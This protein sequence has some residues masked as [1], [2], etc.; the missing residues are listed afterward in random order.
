M[1][2]YAH[3]SVGVIHVRPLLNLKQQS[4]V[5][6]MASISQQAFDLVREYGGSW[7]GEHGDGLV[8][9]YKVNE[10]FGDQIYSA[11]KE[12][13]ATFDP[14]GLMNPGKIVDAPSMTENLRIHPGYETDFPKTYYRFSQEGGLDKAIELCTGVGQC[15]K[16]LQGVMCPS[17]I[18]T[19]DEEH[20]T[21]GR[22]NALRS[23]IAGDLG[24]EG[25]T[26]RRLFEVLDL[27]LECKACKSECPSNVDMAKMKAEF[28]A[29][30][31]DRHGVPL[32]KRIVS[33]TR[34]LAEFSSHVPR[35]SNAFIR[36][37][38]V[39]WFLE[40]LAGIDRRRQL[41]TYAKSTLVKWCASRNGSPIQRDAE[42]RVALFV[43]T[44]VNYYE[45]RIGIAAVEV[46]EAL[47]FDVELAD[48]GCCGRPLISAGLLEKAKLNGNRILRGL[49]EFARDGVPIVVLEP[50]CFST[51]KDDFPDLLDD[52][53]ASRL[54]A[55][56]VYSFEGFLNREEIAPRL[57]GI[58][59]SGPQE[60]LFHGHC[61]QRALT[62]IEDSCEVLSKLENTEVREVE[63]GCCGMAGVF[64]YE[65]KH[66]S[67]SEKI[68]GRNLFPAVEHADCS[69]EVVAGGFSCR[70]Q[71]AHFTGKQ[72]LHPAEILADALNTGW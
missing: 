49:E 21:R 1:A 43:D 7:S 36:N 23:A 3:A 53:D 61:Q 17:F 5:E 34:S 27:C 19:R 20:S 18:A 71:I 48:V 6:I 29:H 10:F 46:L 42:K 11:F 14:S 30:Y 47:G 12:V 50:S 66:Y 22:A 39:R 37:R 33:M 63:P 57:R 58:L 26:S 52:I 59:G 64:G 70:S 9:S 55:Q 68:G 35:L 28:L 54:V 51:L 2:L 65:K 41:P 16:T 32:D 72:A 44:F 69:S 15:R 25:F 67:L 31:Y 40:K 62:G 13:K 45:P 4:D 56:H 60:V 24:P 38:V 8:R